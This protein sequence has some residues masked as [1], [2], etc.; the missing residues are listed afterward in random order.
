MKKTI[1]I[2]L[3]G[4]LFHLDEEAYQRILAYL[5]ALKKQFNSIQGCEEIIGDIEARLAELFHERLHGGK[6]VIGLAEVEEAIRTLGQPEDFGDGEPQPPTNEATPSGEFTEKRVRRLYRDVENGFVG[7]V[8]G[9]LAAYF[10]VD[11]VIFR[12]LF[13][14]LLVSG[15]GF[16]A[17]IILWAAIPGARTTAEKLAMRGEDITLDNIKKSV[18]E[19]AQRMK[20]RFQAGA[21]EITPAVKRAAS[22]VGGATRNLI[23]AIGGLVA[24]VFR[25]IGFFLLLG[26]A[27]AGIALIV[28]ATNGFSFESDW[29]QGTPLF[30]M[31][32]TVLPSSMNMSVLWLATIAAILGIIVEITALVLRYTFRVDIPRASWRWIH[33]TAILSS[34]VGVIIWVVMG[35]QMGLEFR[36]E[37]RH[38]E[39][40]PLA[41]GQTEWVLTVASNELDIP[42]NHLSLGEFMDGLELYYDGIALDVKQSMR[43]TPSL[44]CVVES[45]G[46]NRREA[47]MKADRVHYDVILQ[48]DS[49]VL[50]DLISFPLDDRFRGQNARF[51]LYLPV[52]HTVYLD[53]SCS[54]YLDRVDNIDNMYDPQMAGKLWMMT[55]EG[56]SL[57]AESR[58]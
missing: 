17:Y 25:V 3:A 46:A 24:I 2:N 27:A 14:I 11:P 18:E 51:T 53:E 35:I 22:G 36:E 26:I 42:N 7:G 54:D 23:E 58:L 21:E 52:G 48:G 13:L 12:V 4:M 16:I 45:H 19:E 47:R 15:M 20:A 44:E 49:I 9:G 33:G 1:D 41:E 37:A 57:Y 6:Q 55:E 32:M 39:A 40:I 30:A 50:G 31:A 29:T 56:F 43:Q 8:C 38:I 34:L 28:V 10:R 5:E